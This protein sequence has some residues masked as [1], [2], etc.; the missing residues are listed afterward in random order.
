MFGN[1]GYLK[2]SY[3]APERLFEPVWLD[4]VTVISLLLLT[5]GI[6]FVFLI[7]D[8]N[9]IRPI[10]EANR[11]IK[12]VIKR[13]DASMRLQTTRQDEIGHL[14]SSFNFFLKLIENKQKKLSSRNKRLH[15]MSHSDG[16]TKIANRRA[17]KQ[18]FTS[19]ISSKQSDFIASMIICD[20]DYFKN[21]NDSYGHLAG[22]TALK[23]VAASL[24]MN[25]H[26]ETGIVARIGGEEFA[27]ILTNTNLKQAL[28]VAENLRSRIETL[29]ILHEGSMV[30]EYLT[31]SMGLTTTVP[32]NNNSFKSIFSIADKALY[33]A[34]SSGRNCVCFHSNDT[35]EKVASFALKE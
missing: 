5:S 4:S 29:E 27:I 11:F 20:I 23:A 32:G 15:E 10:K 30:S 12:D 26:E 22:D 16:L 18:F 6:F 24:K 9:Y 8:M 13:E 34:K 7:L 2:F 31:I 35:E 33:E 14:F 21:Y 1:A 28:I 19:F 25:L 17:L 3:Q